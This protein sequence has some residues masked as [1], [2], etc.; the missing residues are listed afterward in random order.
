MTIKTSVFILTVSVIKIF[1]QLRK[2]Y[3]D[4]KDKHIINRSGG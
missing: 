4:D 3:F 2:V 1:Q